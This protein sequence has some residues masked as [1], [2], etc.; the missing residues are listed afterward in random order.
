MNVTVVKIKMGA[1]LYPS[2]WICKNG[3]ELGVLSR[4][5]E[6]GE[7]SGRRS[8]SEAPKKLEKNNPSFFC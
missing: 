8:K 5:F 1:F 7:R 6:R 2:L 4:H 3:K